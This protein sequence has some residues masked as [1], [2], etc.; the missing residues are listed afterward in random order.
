MIFHGKIAFEY[1]DSD[2][3]SEL[4]VKYEERNDEGDVDSDAESPPRQIRISYDP[5]HEHQV[6]GA[7]TVSHNLRV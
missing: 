1:P 6:N 5:P 4:D 7:S 3:S 2:V